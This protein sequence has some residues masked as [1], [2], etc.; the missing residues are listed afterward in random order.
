VP[1]AA[2]PKAE[3]RL[4]DHAGLNAV[5]SLSPAGVVA[6]GATTTIVALPA[7]G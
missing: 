7:G 3:V 4:L 5:G 1:V 2:F 6:W